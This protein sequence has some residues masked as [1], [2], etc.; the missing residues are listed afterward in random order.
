MS[1]S[2]VMNNNKIRCRCDFKF[3]CSWEVAG[4]LV[5]SNTVRTLLQ[6]LTTAL[7]AV[8]AESFNFAAVK[9]FKWPT[10]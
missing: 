3:N 7:V 4:V 6:M 10:S 5:L 1:P 2:A 9:R 8:L